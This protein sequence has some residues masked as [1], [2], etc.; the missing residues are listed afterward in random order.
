M[1]IGVHTPLVQWGGQ[2]SSNVLHGSPAAFRGWQT[3][4]LLD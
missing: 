1:V 4:M 3:G 2:H